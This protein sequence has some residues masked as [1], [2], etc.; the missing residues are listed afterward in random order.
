LETNKVIREFGETY[1]LF[2]WKEKYPRRDSGS[3]QEKPIFANKSGRLNSIND[4]EI[5]G[6][7]AKGGASDGTDIGANVLLFRR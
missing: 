4:F 5:T 6:G 3:I 2:E 1:T 7:R